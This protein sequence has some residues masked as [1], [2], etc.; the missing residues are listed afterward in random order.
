MS[1]TPMDKEPTTALGRLEARLLRMENQIDAI[2]Q[3]MDLLDGA[4]TSSPGH[5]LADAFG[6]VGEA[7]A[8]KRRGRKPKE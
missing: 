8:P 2:R 7:D 5:D 6:D 3:R 4:D 1:Y